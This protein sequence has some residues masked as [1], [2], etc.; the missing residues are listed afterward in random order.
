[1]RVYNSCNYNFTFLYISTIE[2]ENKDAQ[3]S[4]CAESWELMQS[5]VGLLLVRSFGN[6]CRL[7]V[8]LVLWS[9]AKLV[10]FAIIPPI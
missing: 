8:R 1:M 2:V 5:F 7:C 10:A 3:A 4:C 6:Q 9:W